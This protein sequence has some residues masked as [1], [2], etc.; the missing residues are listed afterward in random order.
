MPETE[1]EDTEQVPTDETPAAGYT[2]EER[3]AFKA[4]LEDGE[5]PAAPTEE[6]PPVPEEVPDQPAPVVEG[7]PVPTPQATAADYAKAEEVAALKATVEKMTGTAFGK[8]GGIERTLKVIQDRI[9]Q[10]PAGVALELNVEDVFTKEQREDFPDIVKMMGDAITKAKVKGGAGL[11]PTVI[12]ARV[13]QAVGT[14][15]QEMAMGTMDAFREDWKTVVTSKPYETWLAA[16]TP[17]YQEKI[18][19]S[20]EP[21]TVLKSIEQFEGSK[22]PAPKAPARTV[23][24]APPVPQRRSRMATA[25]QPKGETTTHTPT[26]KTEHDYFKEGHQ[27]GRVLRA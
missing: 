19:G 9:E 4:G 27:T 16:Q 24:A 25:V 22:K 12:D 15:R 18:N 8:I 26:A 11:D 5:A 2:D 13:A 3:E 14:I 20:W 10:T 6:T 1:V 7:E 17:E 21:A 23:P